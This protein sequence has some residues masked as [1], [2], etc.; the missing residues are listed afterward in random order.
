MS[1]RQRIAGRVRRNLWPEPI[2]AA[3]ELL[4]R[5]PYHLSGIKAYGGSA[6]VKNHNISGSKRRQNGPNRG[7]G[8][9]TSI[10][11]SWRKVVVGRDVTFDRIEFLT[12]ST[13]DTRGLG[14]INNTTL[15]G[16]D[17]RL[18]RS[19]TRVVLTEQKPPSNPHI[20]AFIH[21]IDMHT[22]LLS[23]EPRWSISPMFSSKLF[24][25]SYVCSRNHH[26]THLKRKKREAL[27]PVNRHGK[28]SG[29]KISFSPTS[30]LLNI[31]VPL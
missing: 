1:G 22:T 24:P 25:I 15:Q 19:F 16:K 11:I 30:H 21:T 27:Y 18:R 17:S 23:A 7:F 12:A 29:R 3:V 9:P 2:K 13:Y 28:G 8:L 4:N 10:K 5:S 31:F 6:H 14:V 26:N 20:Y